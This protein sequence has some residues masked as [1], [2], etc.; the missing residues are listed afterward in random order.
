MP[1]TGPASSGCVQFSKGRRWPDPN[2]EC[3]APQLYEPF[4][5]AVRPSGTLAGF[6]DPHLAGPRR[7][8]GQ[9]RAG[10]AV[11]ASLPVE[12]TAQ[13]PRTHSILGGNPLF[14]HNFA[15]LAGGPLIAA[16]FWRHRYLTD[17]P[18]EDAVILTV[19][20]GTQL[21]SATTLYTQDGKTYA[22]SN[23]LGD[24]VLIAG[25]VPADLHRSEGQARAAK[26]IDQ[27]RQ[28]ILKAPNIMQAGGVGDVINV[29]K[30]LI[31]AE[32]SGN[33]SLLRPP[34]T[35][36]EEMTALNAETMLA[37]TDFTN[38][39]QPQRAARITEKQFAKAA[40][41][42]AQAEVDADLKREGLQDF[43]LPSTELP[44]L[45]L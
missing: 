24:K 12:V 39:D 35:A 5:L 42:S 29:G 34:Q 3:D 44:S 28:A 19:V 8:N 11:R 27:M 6:V 16:I 22:S 15:D 7:P 31:Q 20:R 21:V 13:Q 2:R 37:A 41:A 18:Q 43:M 23:A 1:A 33:Y 32:E 30:K 4:S 26:I 45:N 25:L 9:S 17:H 14:D 40:A 36:A 10:P 38:V